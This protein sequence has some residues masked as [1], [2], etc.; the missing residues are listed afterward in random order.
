MKIQPNC[1]TIPQNSV[2]VRAGCQEHVLSANVLMSSKI[3]AANKLVARAIM[4]NSSEKPYPLF[5][6]NKDIPR[7]KLFD[8]NKKKQTGTI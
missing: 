7:D 8:I 5:K 3:N 4:P 1:L 2:P 6:A